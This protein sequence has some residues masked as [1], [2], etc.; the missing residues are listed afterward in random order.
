[1]RGGPG[2]IR[3]ALVA[4]GREPAFVSRQFQEIYGNGPMRAACFSVGPAEPQK[5]LA[6]PL[7]D[8]TTVGV[9]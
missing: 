7:E 5:P 3:T 2:I 4:R 1:M 6:V 8:Q 9:L